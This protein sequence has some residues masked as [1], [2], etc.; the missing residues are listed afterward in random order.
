MRCL[1]LA[2]MVVVGGLGGLQGQQVAFRTK[3][4]YPVGTGPVAVAAADFHGNGKLDLAVAE[5]TAGT[6]TVLG[7]RGD[8]TFGAPGPAAMLPGGC[9]PNL[10]V[11]GDFNRDGR[12]DA[13]VSCAGQGRLIVLP[14]HGDG[15]FGTPLAT[16]TPGGGT[17]VAG[18]FLNGAFSLAV[19]DF[20]GTG[21]LDVAVATGAANGSGG[22]LYVMQGRGDGT[23]PASTAVDLSGAAPL[24][25]A[26]GDFN[27]DGKPDLAVLTADASGATTSLRIEIGNGRGGFV[28]GA[29]YPAGT[30]TD[31]RVADLNGDGLADIFLYGPLALGAAGAG[32]PTT[33]LMVY[34]GMG[35]ARFFETF[36]DGGTF[37]RFAFGVA[38]ADVRGTGKP[39]LVEAMGS[40]VGGNFQSA[41]GSLDVRAND[42]TGRFLPPLSFAIRAGEVAVGLALGNL[43]GGGRPD[44]ALVEMPAAG[45]S[46]ALANA[47]AGA[48][49]P[50]MPAGQVEIQTNSSGAAA[51][52]TNVN[53]ASFVGASVAADSIV[54][55]FGNGMAAGMASA[56]GLP[57]PTQLGGVTVTVMDAGGASR[58]APLFYVSPGQI[59]YA[60]P[61][62]T[63]AGIATI[64]ITGGGQAFAVQQQIAPVAPGLFGVNGLA[65]GMAA[66]VVNGAT[67]TA[68]LLQ[69]GMG[70]SVVPA[71]VDVSQGQVF[72]ELFGTGI[73]H[74]SGTVTATLGSVTVPV[75]YAGAQGSYTGVDQVNI[76]LPASL[77]GA[78]MIPVR[79]QVD[80]AVSNVLSVAVK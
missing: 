8:G 44:A 28:T 41:S 72:L 4:W 43:S 1:T 17:V 39:D 74:H 24:S 66:T 62:G 76:P 80:G 71:V 11:A 42:G 69:S 75:S 9:A 60:M 59:N 48:G 51:G 67:V 10:V 73:R 23:F 77:Q 52:F 29:V 16:L 21:K 26:A 27:G 57:L 33:G 20:H 35:G 31:L 15:S 68:P 49:L 56:W 25:V 3:N 32:N 22:T 58:A 6:V 14:G 65:A 47:R 5:A 38:L 64:T 18:N 63:A 46:G 79:L 40:G 19:G 50:A 54:S 61:A 13:L 53:G 37:G 70:G 2:M 30:A 55:A 34:T 12:L 36:S 78:G 45:L 7:G